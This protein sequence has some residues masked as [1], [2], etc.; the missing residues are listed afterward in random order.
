M[1]Q[2]EAVEAVL[3]GRDAVVLLPTG[4]GKSICYQVPALVA[5]R[6][7]EGTTIVVSVDTAPNARGTIRLDLED[8]GAIVG[9]SGNPLVDTHEGDESYD[10]D[11]RA[12][13]ADSPAA[14][15]WPGCRRVASACH[16]G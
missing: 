14:G 15:A 6:R 12:A 1:G 3:L 11:R 10:V 13:P 7:G 16:A 2:V 8:L 5:A 9:A 4:S